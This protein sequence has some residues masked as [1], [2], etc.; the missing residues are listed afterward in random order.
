[1][2]RQGSK[3]ARAMGKKTAALLLGLANVRAEVRRRDSPQCVPS[4]YTGDRTWE[5]EIEER[6]KK[7]IYVVILA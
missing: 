2:G 4:E 6:R 7:G 1:M 5:A 3:S